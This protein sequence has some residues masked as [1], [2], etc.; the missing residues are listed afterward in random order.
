MWNSEFLVTE[1][2]S[3]IY[4]GIYYTDILRSQILRLLPH[5]SH[6]APTVTQVNFCFMGLHGYKTHLC[7][8]SRILMKGRQQIF[9][10]S[11]RHALQ[12]LPH[13]TRLCLQ[14]RGFRAC[15]PGRIAMKGTMGLYLTVGSGQLCL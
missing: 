14:N 6:A 10:R 4:S 9:H 13:P 15:N 11:S 7:Q 1:E 8:R 3:F 5:V 12:T 2:L